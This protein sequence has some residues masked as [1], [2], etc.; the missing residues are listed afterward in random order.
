MNLSLSSAPISFSRQPF[1]VGAITVAFDRQG[2][3]G[4]EERNDLKKIHT[5]T[6]WQG[7]DLTSVPN[8]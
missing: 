1:K 4:S 5:A 8:S 2:N 3:R 7:Q 6:K